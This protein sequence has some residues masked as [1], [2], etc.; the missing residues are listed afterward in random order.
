LYFGKEDD[1]FFLLELEIFLLFPSLSD[2]ADRDECVV[3]EVPKLLDVT[4]GFGAKDG[5]WHF[6]MESNLSLALAAFNIPLVTADA[7]SLAVDDA[8]MF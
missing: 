2:E 1:L 6:F 8:I 5:A 3:L 7:T 4:A